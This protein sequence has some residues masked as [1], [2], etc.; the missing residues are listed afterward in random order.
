MAKNT[1]VVACDG[2]ARAGKTTLVKNFEK[3]LGI[4]GIR[5]GNIYRGLALLALTTLGRD[6]LD[7]LTDDE[8]KDAILRNNLD[9]FFADF[10]GNIHYE[11]ELLRD[12]TRPM[13]SNT[14]YIVAHIREIRDLIVEPMVIKM[15]EAC[16]Y[17]VVIS[18]GRDEGRLWRDAGK[19]GIAIFLSV[20]PLVAAIRERD[21]RQALG[22]DQKPLL[23]LMSQL[24]KYDLDNASR[25]VHPT[26]VD[27][28]P[29][30]FT[31]RVDINIKRAINDKKQI[32]VP[33]SSIDEAMVFKRIQTLLKAA[34]ITEVGT[35]RQVALI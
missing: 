19:L 33:T 21:M 4:P 2:P 27:E 30:L 18:E 29:V 35:T 26:F 12:L 10:E 7:G 20:D 1:R 25:S 24:M 31:G 5:T 22:Y 9:S 28:E 17:P 23:E 15:V 16:N 13:L 14:A 11:G 8:I 34:G 32:V 6:N 3:K